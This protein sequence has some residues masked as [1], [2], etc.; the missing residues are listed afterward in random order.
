MISFFYFLFEGKGLGCR[1]PRLD[2]QGAATLPL[3]LSDGGGPQGVGVTLPGHAGRA[4]AYGPY[5][6]LWNSSV[7]PPSME[8]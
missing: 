3:D 1:A 2:L 8:T 6:C 7:W 4:L 5:G